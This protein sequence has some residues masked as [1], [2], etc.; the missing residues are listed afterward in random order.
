MDET[1]S[2]DT[3]ERLLTQKLADLVS[4]LAEHMKLELQSHSVIFPQSSQL[5]AAKEEDKTKS[6]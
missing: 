2:E 6:S 4:W 5:R 3:T 1:I